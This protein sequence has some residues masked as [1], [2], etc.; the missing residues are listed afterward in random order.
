MICFLLP[1]QKKT[2]KIPMTSFSNY[3][4]LYQIFPFHP[5]LCYCCLYSLGTVTPET[6][7]QL[8]FTTISDTELTFL[9]WMEEILHQLIWWFIPLSTG[10]QPSKAQ[11][12]FHPQYVDFGVAYDSAELSSQVA[13]LMPW[14]SGHQR[15]GGESGCTSAKFAKNDAL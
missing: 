7:A 15:F 8:Q 3:I 13:V 14:R 1:N 6:L 2:S 10:F 11:D 9:L 4:L 5:G 12:F